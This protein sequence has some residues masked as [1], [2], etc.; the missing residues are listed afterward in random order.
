[1]SSQ[2]KNF[3]FFHSKHYGNHRHPNLKNVSIQ[4]P[5]SLT[6]FFK[7]TERPFNK[8][9]L[10]RQTHVGHLLYL[11]L[12]SGQTQLIS[13]ISELHHS[14]QFISTS[15]INPSTHVPSPPIF[16]LIIWRTSQRLY[17]FLLNPTVATNQG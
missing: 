4:R 8:N 6:T 9:Q 3:I 10:T 7:N 15:P 1:M 12:C 11:A 13:Q 5:I 2:C 16:P 17:F 14:G